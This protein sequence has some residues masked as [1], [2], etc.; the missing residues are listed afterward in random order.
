MKKVSL[1]TEKGNINVEDFKEG[2][3][4]P[5]WL[6]AFIF[7]QLRSSSNYDTK[8]KRMGCGRNGFGGKN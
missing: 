5:T 3:G 8:V 1:V 6:P 7:G 2:L 4:T